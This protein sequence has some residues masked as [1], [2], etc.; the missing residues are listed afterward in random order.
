MKYDPMS[1]SAL[2]H[3]IVAVILAV[4]CSPF[5]YGYIGD[6]EKTEQ[7]PG[8]DPEPEPEPEPEK[9][10]TVYVSYQTAEG[11]FAGYNVDVSESNNMVSPDFSVVPGDYT[12]VSVDPVTIDFSSGSPVPA[13]VTFLFAAPEPE[14][15]PE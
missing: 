12:A 6:D 15:E 8:T 13:S 14:P 11:E 2:L 3:V 10:G 1:P 7:T 9:T 4:S 5:N